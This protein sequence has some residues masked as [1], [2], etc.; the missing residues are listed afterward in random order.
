MQSIRLGSLLHWAEQKG[1]N[2]N[3]K[4]Y[5]MRGYDLNKDAYNKMMFDAFDDFVSH[6]KRCGSEE[7]FDA[8]KEVPQNGILVINDDEIP[9]KAY[10]GE[11]AIREIFIGKNVKSIGAE[12]FSMCPNIE[13]IKVDPENKKFTDG[14]CNAILTQ[15]GI[16]LVGCYKTKITERVR[17]IAPFA[18]CGQTLLKEI[19]IPS[20]V[21]RIDAYAFDGCS[22]AQSLDIQGECEH[23][24]DFCFRNCNSL[25]IV[26]FPVMIS[27]IAQTAF[28]VEMIGGGGEDDFWVDFVGGNM[29]VKTIY[30]AGT[31]MQYR[32]LFMPVVNGLLNMN[33]LKKNRKVTVQC[34]DGVYGQASQP[35]DECWKR[36]LF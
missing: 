31:K 3:N 5:T 28:G 22:G 6:G 24:G 13:S 29:N 10:K 36:G 4:I 17:Q 21:R 34:V 30:Y 12:A 11:L 33:A 14:G 19:I 8:I 15:D 16:L 23:I 20:W 35:T 18:F 25:E 1:Y 27:G 26:H 32:N 2:V 7:M 9:A